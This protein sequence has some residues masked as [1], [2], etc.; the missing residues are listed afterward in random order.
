MRE[1][2]NAQTTLFDFYAKHEFGQRLKTLSERL[3]HYPQILELIAE[4][5]DQANVSSTGTRGLSLES[6]FRCLV[7][8]QII[9]LS[10]DKLAFHLCDSGT[11]RSF[12]R[13]RVNQ[14]PSQSTLQ[15]TVKRVKPQTLS[16]THQLL[17]S[18]WVE[19]GEVSLD[20]LRIDSTVI[21][22]HIAPPM[23]SGLLEDDIRVLSRLMTKSQPRTNVKI[24]FVDQRKRAKSLAFRIFHAKKPEKDR[25]YPDLLRCAHVVLN[26]T[27]KA[28]GLVRQQAI[29]V[30]QARVWIEEVEHDRDGLLKVIDQTQR[31]V[32]R[33]ESVP[34][35]EKIV[36]PFEPHT[37]IICS[38]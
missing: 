12:T 15:A 21:N 29:E 18:D 16:K 17:M 37:D 4:D 3:D 31:R 26:Q 19:Q 32:L 2:R 36:S 25:L 27:T 5:F 10:Y 38:R 34:T 28:I 30:A 1:T 8:K 9:Q 20:K 22:S 7:L 33:G 35:D 23:D 13:L 6:I 11:Y 14:S 24:R